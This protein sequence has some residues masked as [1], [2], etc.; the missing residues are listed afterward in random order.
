MFSIIFIQLP[1]FCYRLLKCSTVKVNGVSSQKESDSIISVSEVKRHGLV[2]MMRRC[3][4]SAWRLKQD[5][6]LQSRHLYHRGNGQ[7]P[8]REKGKV[9][10]LHLW[11]CH[12]FRHKASNFHINRRIRK[13]V[14]VKCGEV[15]TKAFDV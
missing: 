5:G 7:I 1:F 4:I 6:G 13:D 3:D 2:T 12:I 10:A 14:A 11:H 15:W 8:W 9:F